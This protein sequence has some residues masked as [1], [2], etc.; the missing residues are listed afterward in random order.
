MT[1][2]SIVKGNSQFVTKNEGG[3]EMSTMVKV[4]E[5]VRYH[6]LHCNEI[7][8]KKGRKYCNRDCYNASRKTGDKTVE[9]PVK[10]SVSSEPVNNIVAFEKALLNMRK[11]ESALTLHRLRKLIDIAGESALVI[12]VDSGV[13]IHW[14]VGD[15]CYIVFYRPGSVITCRKCEFEAMKDSINRLMKRTTFKDTMRLTKYIELAEQM[16]GG[17]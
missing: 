13:A 14:V 3:K 15:K 11:F 4:N 16:K 2:V 1:K 5:E 10:T 8:N 9:A 17:E 12:R 7:L 6:C